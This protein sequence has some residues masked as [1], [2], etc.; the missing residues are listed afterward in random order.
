[1]LL[2]WGI[3][4]IAP[5]GPQWQTGGVQ[6]RCEDSY[7]N[8]YTPLLLAARYGQTAAVHELLQ[9]SRDNSGNQANFIRHSS[10]HKPQTIRVLRTS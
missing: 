2:S 10:L 6:S 8:S 1:M 4:K 9:L 7:Y 5:E 3:A